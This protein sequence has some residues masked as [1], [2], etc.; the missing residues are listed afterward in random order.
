VVATSRVALCQDNHDAPCLLDPL[1]ASH[2]ILVEVHDNA[3]FSS[4]AICTV[5]HKSKISVARDIALALPWLVGHFRG[6]GF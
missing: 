1:A 4:S 5:V 6:R 2:V 3:L